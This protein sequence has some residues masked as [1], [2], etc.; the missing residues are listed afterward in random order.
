MATEQA[1]CT[2]RTTDSNQRNVRIP[3][4]DDL[5]RAL[6]REAEQDHRLATVAAREAIAHWLE[7]RRQ[8][9]IDQAIG[10]YAAAVAG[11][12]ADLDADLEAASLEVWGSQAGQSACR[13]VGLVDDG[14]RIALGLG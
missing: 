13:A 3:L 2:P 1:R 8:Q 10:F 14:L 7:Q 11:S 4:P 9:R 12:A 5:Y 6:Q